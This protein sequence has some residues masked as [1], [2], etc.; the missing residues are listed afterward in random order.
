VDIEYESIYEIKSNV[1]YYGNAALKYMPDKLN[2][3]QY[4]REGEVMIRARQS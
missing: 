3:N 2:P 4:H 1:P